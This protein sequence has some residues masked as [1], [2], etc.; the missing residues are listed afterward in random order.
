MGFQLRPGPSVIGNKIN[1]ALWER[2][3]DFYFEKFMN[4]K[5][6]EKMFLWRLVA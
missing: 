4:G 5:I 1:K 2:Y 6:G 3:L